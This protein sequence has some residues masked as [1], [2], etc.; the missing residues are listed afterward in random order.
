MTPTTMDAREVTGRGT[1]AVLPVTTAIYTVQF[2]MNE[3]EPNALGGNHMDNFAA[4]I[5]RVM[6]EANF[7]T[8]LR[9]DAVTFEVVSRIVV[10]TTE[11]E[12]E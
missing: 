10:S 3:E 9:Y 12:E 2:V 4:E 1:D 8:A 11:V 7:T 6:D 5:Q